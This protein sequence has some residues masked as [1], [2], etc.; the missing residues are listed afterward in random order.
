MA[1]NRSQSDSECALAI[2]EEIAQKFGSFDRVKF[3]QKLGVV[4]RD[5]PENITHVRQCLYEVALDRRP[6]TLKGPLVK[7]NNSGQWKAIDK[8]LENIY[9]LFH[10]I[11]GNVQTSEVKAV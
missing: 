3:K 2:Y 6:D 7:R 5:S 1:D 4:Y 8:L 10:Y 9:T 11:E